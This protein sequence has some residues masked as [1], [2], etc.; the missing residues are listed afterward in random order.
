MQAR[1]S[2]LRVLSAISLAIGAWVA[3]DWCLE[4][5][6]PL[7]S[8][9][10][11]ELFPL[12]TLQINAVLRGGQPLGLGLS[13]YAMV[14]MTVLL[15][16]LL[17]A[18]LV[19]STGTTA[20]T[21]RLAL[22]LSLGTLSA[23]WFWFLR[24][25]EPSAATLHGWRVGLDIGGLLAGVYG[26]I[27]LVGCFRIYPEPLTQEFAQRGFDAS[28]E[29]SQRL[30]RNKRAGAGIW[31][32]WAWLPSEKYGHHGR[33]QAPGLAGLRRVLQSRE[34][35]WLLAVVAIAIVGPGITDRWSHHPLAWRWLTWLVL[36]ATVVMLL[37]PV[38]QARLD[39]ETMLRR[40]AR[41]NQS[42]ITRGELAIHRFV[43]TLPG[44]SLLAMFAVFVHWLWQ[45][46]PTPQLGPLLAMLLILSFTLLTF[47]HAVGLLFLNWRHGTAES[48]RAIGWIFLGTG[49]AMLAWFVATLIIGLLGLGRWAVEV[50]DPSFDR[51]LLGTV[52]MLGPSLVVLAH[53]LSLW[54]SVLSRGSFDARLAL[55]RGSGIAAMGVLSTALFVA[56]EGAISSQVVVRLGMP[57]EAGSLLAGT[58]VAL[59]FVPI[60]N[61]VDR[62][63]S[64]TVQRLLPAEAL[65]AGE[66][67]ELAIVFADLSGYTRLSETDETEAMTLAAVLHQAARAVAA[68]HGGR[69][70]KTIGDAVLLVFE[71]A[72]GAL[73]AVA[74]LHR[75]YDDEVQQRGL[76]HLPVHSGIHLGEVVIAAGG[77]VFGASVNLAARLQALAGP[78]EVV[79]SASLEPAIRA[80]GFGAEL[81][82]ARRFKNIADP[83]DCW[84]WRVTG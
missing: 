31:R 46:N 65:I 79:T 39:D 20:A 17:A 59:A 27:A 34:L 76:E 66:R 77:D 32:L 2:G 51:R 84:R 50:Q 38:A 72:E 35:L 16:P 69:L 15:A 49:G 11:F 19:F 1:V 25:L 42:L 23:A 56:L 45:G 7:G 58:L 62:H 67:K 44:L 83:V 10:N 71:T 37:D 48:R 14:A 75:R 41:K 68:Q 26:L 78:G 6:L 36:A 70:V 40:V 22:A 82:P 64:R 74:A 18:R 81:L 29:W 33:L 54:L 55:R 21:R 13:I 57:S 28:F 24:D 8:G 80:L 47:G 4:P 9:R 12:L 5:R 30:A 3:I 73:Q 60:R 61:R 52:I 43:G 53:V 63:V